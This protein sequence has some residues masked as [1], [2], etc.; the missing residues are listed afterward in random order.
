M[1][2]DNLELYNKFAARLK[3][4]IDI[5]FVVVLWGSKDSLESIKNESDVPFYSYEELMTSG[6]TSRQALAAV[7][8][9][10]FTF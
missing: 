2:V 5:K 8:S 3:G 7:A 1:V 10:G 4:S 6:R 9:S